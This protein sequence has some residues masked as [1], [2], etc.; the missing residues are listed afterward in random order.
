M[1]TLHTGIRAS[2]DP[3]K[4]M[5]AVAELGA[6]GIK[7][8]DKD[9]NAMGDGELLT[10]RGE[11][12][13]HLN[14]ITNRAATL[15]DSTSQARAI[16][17]AEVLADQIGWASTVLDMRNG[18][19]FLDG[20]NPTGSWRDESGKPVTV[21]GA[22]HSGRVAATMGREEQP[23]FGIA[24]FIRGVAGLRSSEAVRNS[25]TAGTDSAGGYAV[26]SILLP[27][28][29]E[30]LIPASTVLQAGGR[31]TPLEKT[32][33][34][35]R[36]ARVATVPS[37]AWRSESGAVALS[38]PAFSALDLTPQDLSFYF[39]VSRELLADS[40]NI[41]AMLV[42]AIAG[43]FAKELDRAS[44]RGTGSAPEIRGLLNITNVNAVSNGTNGAS[45]ATTKWANITAAY[46]AILD[47]NAPPPTAC[48]M[49]NRSLVGF[50]NMADTTGQ[51]LERPSLLDPMKFLGTS[52]VPV[53]LTVGSSTDCTEMYVG[54][55]TNFLIGMREDVSFA[56]A[57]QVFAATG[58]VGF[59]CHMRVDVGATYPSAFAK[60]TG[61]KP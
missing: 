26:P 53:N 18:Q 60:I 4:V 54:D 22:E 9:F 19:K 27:Q 7:M 48:I 52:Q 41:D 36:L 20:N 8:P 10:L 42:S 15:Q 30:A 33:K 23:S 61:I 25:L 39:K 38:D 37:A 3:Q 29:I 11:L 16:D 50:A 51:P 13:R 46:L 31:V 43:A 6:R 49:A 32:A 40:P 59:F 35:F 44:L 28:F 5:A 57:D 24:D 45:L 12:R 47:A 58:E 14:D 55:F 2:R 34:T 56:R 17:A 1:S 21:L